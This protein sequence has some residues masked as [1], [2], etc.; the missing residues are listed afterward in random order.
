MN[1]KSE[2]LGRGGY[3]VC[4]KCGNKTPHHRGIPCQDER[5]TK[6]ESKLLR[7][8]SYHHELLKKKRNK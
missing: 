8:N 7:E 6:C 2:K 4:P 1:E 3:C 5:C